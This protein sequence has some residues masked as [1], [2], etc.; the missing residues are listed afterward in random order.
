MKGRVV[1][2]DSVPLSGAFMELLATG[3]TARTS[4]NGEFV[5]SGVPVGRQILRIRMLGYSIKQVEITVVADAGWTGTITLEPS[6]VS[7]PE[8]AVTSPYDKPEAYAKTAKYDDFFRR[9]KL[10]IGTFRTRE[11]IEAKASYD[12]VSVLQGIPSVGVSMTPNP[13]TNE[14]EVRFRLP[15][16]QPP[17]IGFYIDG[18]KVGN[19]LNEPGKTG[20]SSCEDCAR[21]AAAMSS[22]LLR[23]IEFVEFYRGPSQVPPEFDRGDSCAALVVWTR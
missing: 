7:L 9:R 11:D 16:C 20:G 12:L 6:A 3:D 1:A 21:L 4:V 22:V 17:R 10:G 19:Y 5:L 8:V 18:R 13:M 15:R 23:D 14:V 2:A